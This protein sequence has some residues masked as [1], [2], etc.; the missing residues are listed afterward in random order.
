MKALFNWHNAFMLAHGGCRVQ[1]EQTKAA[2]V[3]SNRL[4]PNRGHQALD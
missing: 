3:G 2:V 4:L 1:I